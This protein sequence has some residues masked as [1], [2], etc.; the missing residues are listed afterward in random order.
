MG[1][2][3]PG[4]MMNGLDE[5]LESITDKETIERWKRIA[6]KQIRVFAKKTKPFNDIKP[7][8]YYLYID[9]KTRTYAIE[10]SGVKPNAAHAK[11]FFAPVDKREAAPKPV[12]V[13]FP[14]GW[15]TVHTVRKTSP[16][17]GT[18]K[19]LQTQYFG[20]S[21]N[22]AAFFGLKRKTGKEAFGLVDGV[23]VP[24]YS[25]KGFVEYLTEDSEA[26]LERILTEAGYTAINGG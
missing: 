9:A 12:H 5:L 24:V 8:G 10:L 19:R 20:V 11:G 6:S 3:Y 4:V 13:H 23:A 15:R 2:V 14:Q 25:D 1:L 16:S 18:V 26:E 7:S 17:L 22:P 21:G